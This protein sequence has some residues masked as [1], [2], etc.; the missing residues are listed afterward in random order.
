VMPTI[1]AA[2]FSDR[3]KY[4]SQA[5]AQSLSAEERSHAAVVQEIARTPAR[6]PVTGADIAGAEPWHRGA[7]GN[8]LRA[9]IGSV[10][11]ISLS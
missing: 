3:D 9:G 4:A 7:S 8:N 10:L 11:G 1:A 5:D 6:S 2:E